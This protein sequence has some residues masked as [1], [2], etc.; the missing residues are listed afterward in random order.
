MGFLLM[1]GLLVAL[2]VVAVRYGADSRDGSA[3][4]WFDRPY[5]NGPDISAT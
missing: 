1:T 2:S 4:G 5:G 3:S